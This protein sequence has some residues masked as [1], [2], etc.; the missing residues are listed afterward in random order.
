MTLP[1]KTH[2][3]SA[4]AVAAGVSK[5][6]AR[7]SGALRG[8]RMIHLL[9]LCPWSQGVSGVH[10]RRI[11]TGRGRVGL[12]HLVLGHHCADG[13]ARTGVRWSARMGLVGRDGVSQITLREQGLFR[14]QRSSDRY[15]LSALVTLGTPRHGGMIAPMRFRLASQ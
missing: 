4:R 1:K 6:N 11:L 9:F 2:A 12:A 10:L 5:E 14:V 3:H 15:I 13:G 8:S 7:S